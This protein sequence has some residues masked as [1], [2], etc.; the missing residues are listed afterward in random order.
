MRR[1]NE[2]Q[3]EARKIASELRSTTELLSRTLRDN[4]NVSD[5]VVKAAADR[6][7]LAS[8]LSGLL[9]EI[10]EK[11]TYSTL[12]Q[13]VADAD[14]REKTMQE[15]IERERAATARVREVKLLLKSERDEHEREVAEKKRLLAQLKQELKE[16][17]DTSLVEGSYSRKVLSA[18]RA[19]G[20]AQI[21]E[22]LAALRAEEKVLRQKLALE[23]GAH[24]A[25]ADFLGRK[26]TEMQQEVMD[27]ALRHESSTAA[28]DKELGLLKAA[29][30][31]DGI[32]MKE[33]EAALARENVL[34][35]QIEL[36]MIKRREEE[37]REK[38]ARRIQR[39]W[40]RYW[41][42]KK[43]ALLNAKGK[44]GAGKGKGKQ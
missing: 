33:A 43:A 21:E 39:C 29:L 6:A 41:E 10:E 36:L 37:R 3:E 27:W 15:T 20:D 5:N 30:V 44:K 42:V 26:A 38:A 31:R 7:A 23:A 35:Q 32:K 25:S 40:R 17:K 12:T 13:F 28:K 22:Q 14:E 24:G 4:P 34:K 16:A 8:V 18:Q 9:F 19:S 2:N 11:G 1:Y